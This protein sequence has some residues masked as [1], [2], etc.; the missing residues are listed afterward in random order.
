MTAVIGRAS[1]YSRLGAQ[2]S[3]GN[4]CLKSE[5]YENREEGAREKVQ[6]QLL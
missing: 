5:L 6:S 4:D 2:G 3:E 1:G